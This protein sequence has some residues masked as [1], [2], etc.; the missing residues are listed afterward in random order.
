MESTS[1]VTAWR[2][3]GRNRRPRDAALGSVVSK[4]LPDVDW[5]KQ[6]RM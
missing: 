5:T 4:T 3:C 1:V 6:Q 2:S